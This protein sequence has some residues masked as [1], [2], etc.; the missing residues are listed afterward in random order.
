MGKKLL[1]FALFLMVSGGLLLFW[2]RASGGGNS[3][4]LSWNGEEI[5]VGPQGIQA[6]DPNPSEPPAPILSPDDLTGVTVLQISMAYGDVALTQGEEFCVTGGEG[7]R[8]QVENGAL[9]MEE[10]DMASG[11][12]EVTLP[13]GLTL[14]RVS[15]QSEIGEIFLSGLNADTLSIQSENGSASLRDVAAGQLTV[16]TAA[17]DVSISRCQWDSATL[18]TEWGDLSADHVTSGGA[19]I[20]SE[21]GDIALAGRLTGSTSVETES[22]DIAAE[23]TL[24]GYQYSGLVRSESGQVAIDGNDVGVGAHLTGGGPHTLTLRSELGDIRLDFGQETE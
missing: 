17:G 4:T 12:V 16:H 18:T 20:S 22:G 23:S 1:S 2:G 7:V 9:S 24:S 11:S 8:L 3:V 5:S 15:I 10:D 19:K 14:E 6:I 21:I 13:E